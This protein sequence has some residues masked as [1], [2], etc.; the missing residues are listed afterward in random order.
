MRVIGL[1]G[2]VGCG[3]STVAALI[4]DNYNALVLIADDIGALLMEPGQRCYEEIIEVFGPQVVGEDQRLDRKSLAS[5][6]FAD[7]KK[8]T[9][10]NQIVHPKVKAF[11]EERIKKERERGQLDYIFIESAII[12]K[13]G[14][15]SI[16]DEFWYVSAPVEERVKRLR[17]NRGYSK[18]KIQA[19][20]SNQ[21][22]EE[23]FMNACSN[24][25]ENDGE[26]KKICDQL[27][28]L[29]VS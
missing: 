8:L 22:E 15:E 1:T 28:N 6:V 23:E 13:C 12:L 26:L 7:T 14:Y 9:V 21:N 25:I 24:V 20:M 11:I 17:L 18:E 16:C 27:K 10:L 19:I 29:L 4:N 2:G 3:K 5:I